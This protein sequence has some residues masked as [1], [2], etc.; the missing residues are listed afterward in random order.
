M[1]GY[2]KALEL[3]HQKSITTDAAL[4]EALSRC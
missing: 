1:T 2:E 3:W 4:A